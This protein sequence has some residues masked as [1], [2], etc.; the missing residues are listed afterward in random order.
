MRILFSLA[1]SCLATH[2]FAQ[3]TPLE[4]TYGE[5]VAMRTLDQRCNLLGMGPRRALAGFTAQ[6][7]GAALRAGSTLSGLNLIY[8]QASAAVSTKPCTDPQVR[9]EAARVVAAHK[10]WRAQMTATYPGTARTWRV[11]RTGM[12][13]WRGVQEL[14]SG[15]RAGLVANGQN[16]AFGL[17]TP[18][19]AASGARLYLRDASRLGDPKTGARLVVPLRIGTITHVA[20]IRRAADSRAR[21][22]LP[23]RA[24]TMLLFPDTTTQ[25]ILNA[26][27]RDSFEIEIIGRGGQVTRAIVEVGD[28][29]AA[30]AFAAEF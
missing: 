28:I 13:S 25:A 24:G 23:P 4:R 14:G 20:S 6:A 9:A 5:R 27:P 22:G 18:D 2:A 12:D 26:D 19:M 21:I 30:Y 11:D 1:L 16:L 29:V 7:R 8:R 10:G 15:L 3:A 17:E